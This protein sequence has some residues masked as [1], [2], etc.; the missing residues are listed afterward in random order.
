MTPLLS[1]GTSNPITTV[2]LPTQPGRPQ[3]WAASAVYRDHAGRIRH[4]RT[5]HT[6]PDA[7]ANALEDTLNEFGIH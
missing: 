2:Q 6:D 5:V 4:L 3:R 7:A 1:P